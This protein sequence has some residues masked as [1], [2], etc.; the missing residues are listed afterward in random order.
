MHGLKQAAGLENLEAEDD[1]QAQGVAQ[2]YALSQGTGAAPEVSS[3]DLYMSAHPP[4]S[5]LPLPISIV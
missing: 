3:L 4:L 1:I 5:L 2:E